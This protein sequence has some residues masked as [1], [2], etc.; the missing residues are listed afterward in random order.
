MA[1]LFASIAD[2]HIYYLPNYLTHLCFS[3]TYANICMCS[4]IKSNTFLAVGV[5]GAVQSCTSKWI[6]LQLIS[7]IFNGKL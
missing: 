3:Q 7:N 2:M 4:I 5:G 1:H 6:G